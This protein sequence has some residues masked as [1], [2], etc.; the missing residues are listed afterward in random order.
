MLEVLEPWDT[1]SGKL[2]T[3]WFEPK[4]KKCATVNKLKGDGDLKSTLTSRTEMQSLDFAQLIFSL[5]LVHYFLSMPPF[6]HLGKVTYIACAIVC[7]KYGIYFLI[8]I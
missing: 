3:E 4:R 7:G 8:L 1:Y 6:F 2:T 5:I